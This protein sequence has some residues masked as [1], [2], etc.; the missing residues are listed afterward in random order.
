M[1]L[2]LPDWRAY[3]PYKAF[4]SDSQRLAFSVQGWVSCLRHNG[5]GRVVCVAHHLTRRYIA[6]VI[7]GL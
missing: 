3:Y 4:K 2:T 7:Q 1:G 6:L 5:L